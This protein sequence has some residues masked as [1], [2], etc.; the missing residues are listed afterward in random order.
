M[1]LRDGYLKVRFHYFEEMWCLTVKS[2][3]CLR[4]GMKDQGGNPRVFV[5]AD[6]HELRGELGCAA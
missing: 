2:K 6:L 1:C 5:V 4:L 3:C